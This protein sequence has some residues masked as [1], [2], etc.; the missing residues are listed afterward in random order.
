MTQTHT[1]PYKISVSGAQFSF[2]TA[3]RS[4]INEVSSKDTYNLTII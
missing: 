2:L 3:S 4:H 1:V